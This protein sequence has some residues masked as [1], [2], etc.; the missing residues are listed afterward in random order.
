MDNLNVGGRT[1]VLRLVTRAGK[2]LQPGSRPLTPRRASDHAIVTEYTHVVIYLQLGARRRS[3]PA[4]ADAARFA[5]DLL[6]AAGVQ[7]WAESIAEADTHT[8]DPDAEMLTA[9][10]E[11]DSDERRTT[12]T[13]R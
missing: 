1:T 11:G 12:R 3:E 9:L 10:Y 8:P 13:R 4:T 6:L 2:L 5:A 7:A